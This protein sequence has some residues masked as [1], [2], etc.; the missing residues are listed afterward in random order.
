[1]VLE[2]SEGE[3]ESDSEALAECVGEP[4]EADRGTKHEPESDSEPDA[5]HCEADTNFCSERHE[6]SA[7]HVPSRSHAQLHSPWYP[8]GLPPLKTGILHGF[9]VLAEPP[10]SRLACV[11]GHAFA[12]LPTQSGRRSTSTH[13]RTKTIG[14]GRS[15]S[16]SF[17]HSV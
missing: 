3:A 10:W 2:Q 5:S 1:M 8:S 14:G 4:A 9:H 12:G 11:M 16:T 13:W 6:H 7:P 17:T 15:S